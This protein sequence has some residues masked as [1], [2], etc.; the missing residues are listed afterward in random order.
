MTC[1]T[2][3]RDG[4]NVYISLSYIA[5]NLVP[6]DGTSTI[7]T[8][9]HSEMRSKQFHKFLHDLRHMKREGLAHL[10]HSSCRTQRK[11]FRS[12]THC[13]LQLSIHMDCEVNRK[14]S[15]CLESTNNS[16]QGNSM[17]DMKKTE[18]KDTARLSNT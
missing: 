4:R 14:A 12:L 1:P 11:N 16:N 2:C 17:A 3:H 9:I 13:L 5:I 18:Q 7:C 15:A 10:S 8:A 6:A